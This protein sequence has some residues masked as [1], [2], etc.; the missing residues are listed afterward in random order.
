MSAEIRMASEED[1]PRIAV[2]AGEIWRKH[3]PGIITNEQ[4]EY[5]LN[6]MFD[7]QEMKRQIAE[8]TIY[9][10]LS[11]DD[12]LGGFTSYG[13]SAVDGEY[14]LDKLYVHERYRGQGLGKQMLGHVIDNVRRAGA[15]TLMLVVNKKNVGAIAMYER[16]G[17]KVRAS[18]VNEIGGGFVMDDFVM[19]LGMT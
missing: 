1:L 12:D 17:F 13:P 11:V 19:E 14:K 3:Y 4:I 16:N 10:T 6:W 7:L 5:M 18:V 2:L 9:E 8:G 15:H